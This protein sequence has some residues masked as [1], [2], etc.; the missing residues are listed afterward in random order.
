MIYNRIP[1]NVIKSVDP[2]T[3]LLLHFDGAD[4]SQTIIDDMRL[5]TL[6]AQNNAQLNT[7]LYKYGPSSLLLDGVSAYV[8]TPDSGDW[9]FGDGAF[10]LEAWVYLTDPFVIAPIIFQ[11][12]D[13]N[14]FFTMS[15]TEGIL[16][17]YFKIDGNNYGR[18]NVE[19]N[20]W[21][22]VWN[23][24]TYIRGWGGRAN[25]FASTINGSVVSIASNV[26]TL[27]DLTGSLQIGADVGLNNTYLLASIDELRISKGIARYTANFTPTGPFLKY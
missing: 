15:L 20:L 4:T 16:D 17:C 27:P 12:T 24:I 3:K 6:T 7:D 19:H 5:H 23:H 26:I 10:T 22:D 25:T 9:N 18:I 1:R 14:N 21:T 8:T 13:A 2:Y 11:M